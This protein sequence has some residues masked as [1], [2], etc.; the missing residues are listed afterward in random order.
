MSS[1]LL[2][3]AQVGI[4]PT[5]SGFAIHRI[6]HSATAPEEEGLDRIELS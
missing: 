2:V 3:E 1:F 5:R 6:S 4:E